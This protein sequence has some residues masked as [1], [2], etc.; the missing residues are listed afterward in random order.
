MQAIIH[1]CFLLQHPKIVDEMH[2]TSE[3]ERECKICMLLEEQDLLG[4][5]RQTRTKQKR[6]EKTWR[7]NQYEIVILVTIYV[8]ISCK[9][10]KECICVFALKESR[11]PLNKEYKLLLNI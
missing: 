8:Y 11:Q 4:H 5:G 2:S 1:L 6:Q 10:S 3:K 7:R 9:E